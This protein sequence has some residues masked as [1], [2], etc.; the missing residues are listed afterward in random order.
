MYQDATTVDELDAIVC[1]IDEVTDSS[2]PTAAGYTSTGSTSLDTHSAITMSGVSILGPVS[3]ND[4][5]PFYP[6]IYGTV[7]NTE[8]AKEGFDMCLGHP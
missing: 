5:D 2:V 6:A 4:V 1:N 7:T 8:N 3:L